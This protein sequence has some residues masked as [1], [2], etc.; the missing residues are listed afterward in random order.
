MKIARPYCLVTKSQ[1]TQPKIPHLLPF[2]VTTQ[3]AQKLRKKK[4]FCALHFPYIPHHFYY[5]DFCHMR[6]YGNKIGKENG[7]Y[8]ALILIALYINEKQL[9]EQG[10][11]TPRFLSLSLF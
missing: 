2:M 1:K 9:K 3:N 4:Y 6:F 8:R 7:A 5:R 10:G 11:E